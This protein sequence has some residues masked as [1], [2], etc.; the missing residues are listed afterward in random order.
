MSNDFKRKLEAYEKGELSG[1]ELAEFEKELERLESYQEYLEENKIA[2]INNS[3]VD[4]KKLQ[5][6][7]RWSKWKARIQTAFSALGMILVF[8]IVSSIF[9]SA[10]YSWGTPDRRDVFR[11]VIDHTL[12]VT[13]PYGD[14]GGTSTNS[15]PYFGL[16][17]TRDINKRIGNDTIKV[18]E[19]NV[20]FLFSMM[21]FPKREYFDNESQ[22]SP[23]FSYLG[24][25]KG[26]QSDWNRLEKL[27]EGT[28]VS[29]FVSLAELTET[30]QVFHLLEGK[31][32]QLLWLAVNTG[33]EGKLIRH[34]GI[35]FDPIGFPSSPIW[36]EDDMIIDSR[37]EEK[38]LFGSRIVSE[39]A[40]SPDYREGD[41]KIY[42]KQFFKTLNFLKQH[43]KIAN[44][45]VFEKLDLSKRINFLKKNGVKHYGIVITG[46]TKEV[47]KLQKEAWV[48][49]I[50]VD[51]VDFWNWE[52]LD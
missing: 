35:I 10:Y 12:T 22:N 11:N 39:S 28:V 30:K 37:K 8:T 41:Q 25:N 49:E 40:S 16:E 2:E 50:Q 15:K 31:D 14:T 42:H 46:P 24:V 52:R 36:H 6:I 44:K 19:L 1:A 43:E 13:Y 48:G 34:E 26:N 20:N 33:K 29:A 27:P 18:G 32:L 5:K 7:L 47:L 4:D 21:S 23:S 38:G 9:T 17:A 51:E 45:L 3:N